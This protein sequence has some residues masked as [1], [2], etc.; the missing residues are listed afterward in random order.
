MKEVRAKLSEN[1]GEGNGV[2]EGT[3]GETV[4]V[5]RPSEQVAACRQTGG[6]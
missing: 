5:L 4:L 1:L 3:G 6:R 2:R